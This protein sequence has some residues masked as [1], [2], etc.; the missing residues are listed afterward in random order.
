LYKKNVGLIYTVLYLGNLYV[1]SDFDPFYRVDGYIHAEINPFY[2]GDRTERTRGRNIGRNGRGGVISDG[3]TAGANGVRPLR[4]NNNGFYDN[5]FSISFTL[6][7][8][9]LYENLWSVVI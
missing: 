2:R 7:K 6:L 4:F 5:L 9:R 3:M 8:E 1:Y